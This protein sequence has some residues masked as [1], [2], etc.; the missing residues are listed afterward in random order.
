M[1]V[2]ED[3]LREV[4]RQVQA[5]GTTKL[6]SGPI[7]IRELDW[8]D[9]VKVGGAT[10]RYDF[11]SIRENQEGTNERDIYGYPCHLV[12]SQGW[13]A[14][15]AEEQ[16]SGA[17]MLHKVHAYFHNKRR[18]DALEVGGVNQQPCVVTSGPRPPSKFQDKKI[19][20]RTIWAWF[21]QPRSVENY[22]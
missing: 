4:A 17:D 8:E 9:V 22:V 1:S 11:N 18:M 16:V 21:L 6:F 20:T 10:I 14:Q 5:I 12:L 2:Y 15:L 19:I 3:A 7:E 13:R